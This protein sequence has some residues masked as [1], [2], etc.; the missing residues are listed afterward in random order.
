MCL[1]CGL[2]VPIYEL[3]KEAKIKDFVETLDNP[4]DVA[5][6]QFLGVD[7]RT[8]SK[9]IKARRKR[10]RQSQYDYINDPQLKEELKKGST[11]L[12][13]SEQLP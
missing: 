13:Y 5:K 3:Q 6:D 10:E 7:K 1:D 9:G 11:L 12:S 4:F 2:V 8:P